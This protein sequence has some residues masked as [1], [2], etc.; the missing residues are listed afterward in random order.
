M[1]GK[2]LLEQA[3]EVWKLPYLDHA[4]LLKGLHHALHV[5]NHAFAGHIERI[6]HFLLRLCLYVALN[7]FLQKDI[8]PVLKRGRLS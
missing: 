6:Q 3:K 2:K 1:R 4:P 8:D 5:V 7:N